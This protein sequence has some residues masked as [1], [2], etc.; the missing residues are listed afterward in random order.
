M[1]GEVKDKIKAALASFLRTCN[2]M[3]TLL[4]RSSQLGC[5]GL[6]DG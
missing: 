6:S 2:I 4:C 3:T 1:V 5:I